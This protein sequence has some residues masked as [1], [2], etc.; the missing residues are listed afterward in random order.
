MVRTNGDPSQLASAARQQLKLLDKDQ[1]VTITTMD[2]IFSQSVASQRFNTVLIGA[3]AALALI[4]AMVGVFG[5]INYSV[6]QRTHELGIRIALGAQRAD[7]FRLVIGNGLALALIGVALGSLGAYGL[8]RLLRG[9]LFGVSPTD[10]LT[11]AIVSALVIGVAL[12]ACYL[13]GRRAMKVDPLEALR[14]E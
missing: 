6:A 13:P 3:F 14:Y 10:G 8:T 11:F 9:L 12:L 2:E 4:L 1:P 5:V 7:V